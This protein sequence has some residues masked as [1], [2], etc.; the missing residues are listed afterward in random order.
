M[1]FLQVG[2]LL[3][4]TVCVLLLWAG[5]RASATTH[6]DSPREESANMPL[7][8]FNHP[9]VVIETQS[10]HSTDFLLEADNQLLPISSNLVAVMISGLWVS[11]V[12]DRYAIPSLRGHVMRALTR[13]GVGEA[14][15]FVHSEPEAGSNM[16]LLELERVCREMLGT[17]L[18]GVFI[19]PAGVHRTVGEFEHLQYRQYNRLRELLDMMLGQEVLIGERYSHVIRVRTDAIWVQ[20][21]PSY[22]DL[23][24]AVPAGTVAVPR[25]KHQI[26]RA[27]GVTSKLV[28]DAFWISS[29]SIVYR[30]IFMMP[31]L[32]MRSLDMPTLADLLNCQDSQIEREFLYVSNHRER[33]RMIKGR[34]KICSE[35]VKAKSVSAEAVFSYLLVR[36]VASE[37]LLDS[38]EITGDFWQYC[39]NC[40]SL[41][42]TSLW[43]P[44]HMWDH[45]RAENDPL[46]IE[47][48]EIERIL[49]EELSRA[50]M[51]AGG[52]R[53]A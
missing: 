50:R 6:S 46:E 1:M 11:G 38:C 41:H 35:H 23:L 24:R 18:K 8:G 19:K 45:W 2:K 27:L 21:F 26:D 42:S 14:H 43:R 39:S 47:M 12:T 37:N 52:E 17:G 49:E 51:R 33:E 44:C 53:D 30:L 4:A 32:L 36:Y 40:L 31:V 34:Q 22:S 5:E 28:T 15:I 29:R 7:H 3:T 16:T 25:P 48:A 9:P 20:D 13:G 10:A